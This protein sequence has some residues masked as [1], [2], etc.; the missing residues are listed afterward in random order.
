MTYADRH[1]HRT[2]FPRREGLVG[3]L[4]DDE[5]GGGVNTPSQNPRSG[6]QVNLER[7]LCRSDEEDTR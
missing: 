1:T 6:G 5:G 3:R 2:V 4:T 7:M